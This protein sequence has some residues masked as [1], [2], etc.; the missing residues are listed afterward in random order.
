GVPRSPLSH[1]G[2]NPGTRGELRGCGGCSVRNGF[3]CAPLLES[4]CRRWRGRRS[5]PD[6]RWSTCGSLPDV[7]SASRGVHSH[8]AILFGTCHIGHPELDGLDCERWPIATCL[9]PS[10]K[11]L[12]SCCQR[13]LA[14]ERD[15]C[16]RVGTPV[17]AFCLCGRDARRP[18]GAD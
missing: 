16:G 10:P 7:R 1:C 18:V 8:V 15:L 11:Q 4:Q 5:L 2:L 12:A 6:H 13:E 3:P 9:G 17:V 14:Q